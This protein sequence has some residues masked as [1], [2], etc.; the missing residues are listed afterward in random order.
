VVTETVTVAKKS[1]GTYPPGSNRWTLEVQGDISCPEAR[2]VFGVYASRKPLPPGWNCSGPEGNVVC[3][4]P[5][6]LL[7]SATL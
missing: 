2:R 6:D 5:P 1:C 4:N 7:I 3:T